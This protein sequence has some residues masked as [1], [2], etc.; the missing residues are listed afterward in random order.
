[1]KVVN[2]ELPESGLV[3]IDCEN[4]KIITA[5]SPQK[6]SSVKNKSPLRVLLTR[7]S[8]NDWRHMF[9]RKNEFVC[10]L[11]SLTDIISMAAKQDDSNFWLK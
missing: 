11:K 6:L 1:M 5:I 2:L 10:S 9:L 3:V 7:E 8:Y 4:K